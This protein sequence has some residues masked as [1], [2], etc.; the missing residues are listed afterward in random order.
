M[1][2]LLA[3]RVA[4]ITGAG[5]GLGRA[6]ALAM[7]RSGARVVVC[8]REGADQVHSAG[9]SRQLRAA[10]GRE[11]GLRPRAAAYSANLASISFTISS[12]LV[13]GE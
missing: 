1:N 13:V 2:G 11:R 9:R 10:A 8:K 6:H 12:G 7:A 5:R 4:I 3:N